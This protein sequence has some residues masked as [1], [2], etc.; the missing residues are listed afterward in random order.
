MVS[1]DFKYGDSVINL[2]LPE[3]NLKV[4]KERGFPGL[5]NPKKKILEA[6]AKKLNVKEAEVPKKVKEIFDEWKKLRKKL[7]KKHGS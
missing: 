1:V 2:Q 7:R 3:E 4:I 6:I 5:E